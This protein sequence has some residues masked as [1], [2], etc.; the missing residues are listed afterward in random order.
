MHALRVAGAKRTVHHQAAEPVGGV[1]VVTLI[2]A[3]GSWETGFSVDLV[4]LAAIRERDSALGQAVAGLPV[5]GE[6]DAGVVGDGSVDD[7]VLRLTRVLVRADCGALAAHVVVVDGF[8]VLGVC[9]AVDV[10][11]VAVIGGD[12]DKGVVEDAEF[13]EAGDGGGNGVVELEE[14]AESAVVVE[15]VH[16]LVDAGGFGHQEEAAVT[17]T[18]VENVDGL[19]CHFL[20]AGEVVSGLLVAAG[21]VG[22]V[23]DILGV[24]VAV[25][26]DGKRAC[27]EE[28][29]GAVFGGQSRE[30]GVVKGNVVALLAE[31]LDVVEA[32]VRALARVEVL[33]S[34][35]EGDIGAV[36]G[37]PCV[38]GDAVEHLVYKRSVVTTGAGVT[39]QGD[40]RGI[41]EESSRDDTNCRAP[42]TGKN[43][44]DRLDLGVIEC[45]WR[46]VTVDA[47]GIDGALVTRVERRG[48]VGGIRD[49]A[50]DGV[51][52]LVT[53]NRELV[54]GHLG[55]VL[56]VDALVADQACSRDHARG[57]T[58]TNEKNDVL[59]LLLLSK[60]ADN[61]VG[62][63]LG[64]IVV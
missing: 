54:H 64:A 63:S 28:S 46:R 26:P 14:V 38:V 45:I 9:G 62:N 4:V 20:E 49:V 23:D 24:H 43:L 3:L 18:L 42:D 53:E 34:S 39:G 5:D 25:E 15:D 35:A 17:A 8:H 12:D 52:H 19:E 51:G 56:A 37:R 61:P 31:L 47:H 10:E 41:S 48:R 6:V 2:V 30:G 29:E 16:L 57:H 59:G 7:L 11:A 60:V 32:L 44:N 21:V 55:Q 58:I 40:G 50:V 13:G 33:S 22:R 36:E 27:A 1:D